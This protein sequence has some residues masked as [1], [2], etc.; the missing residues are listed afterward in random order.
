[1]KNMNSLGGGNNNTE[2]VVDNDE[3]KN[4]EKNSEQGKKS[5]EFSKEDINNGKKRQAIVNFLNGELAA[6][7]KQEVGLGF[8]DEQWAKKQIFSVQDRLKNASNNY[9]ADHNDDA[10]LY[11]V[12]DIMDKINQG[13]EVVDGDE[14]KTKKL[15]NTAKI[16]ESIIS[17]NKKG[18]IS[19]S[20]MNH[21]LNSLEKVNENINKD[22]D[23]R[24]YGFLA[25]KQMKEENEKYAETVKSF[26]QKDEEFRK[27]RSE[28]EAMNG[29]KLT[30]EQRE[31]LKELRGEADSLWDERS[32]LEEVVGESDETRKAKL[33][34]EIAQ[35]E[36]Q[37]AEER[38]KRLETVLGLNKKESETVGDN[39]KNEVREAG[40]DENREGV[41]AFQMRQFMRTGVAGHHNL[42][43][44]SVEKNEKEKDPE[45]QKR[46][47]L[48]KYYESLVPKPDSVEAASFGNGEYIC[49]AILDTDASKQRS[50]EKVIEKRE[51]YLS[52]VDKNEISADKFN[53]L[54]GS[55]LGANLLLN[56]CKIDNGLMYAAEMG[57]E[58]VLYTKMFNNLFGAK[59]KLLSL[60]DPMAAEEKLCKATGK[61]F[62]SD[63]FKDAKGEI[64]KE[65]YEIAL[66]VLN[67]FQVN[68]VN[69]VGKEIGSND[70]NDVIEVFNNERKSDAYKEF[71]EK[72]RM[73][74]FNRSEMGR[75]YNEKKAVADD[76]VKS[77]FDK[78]ADKKVK[79]YMNGANP[80]QSKEAGSGLSAK[81]KEM[82]AEN[83]AEIAK[84][85]RELNLEGMFKRFSKDMA[86]D[87]ENKLFGAS[88]LYRELNS[89]FMKLKKKIE[90]SSFR[91]LPAEEQREAETKRDLLYN[92]SDSLND[93]C[94]KAFQKQKYNIRQSL[95][96]YAKSTK[97]NIIRTLVRNLSFMR[98]R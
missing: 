9:N 17:R 27:K 8:A 96:N 48:K 69:R 44:N 84:D 52:Q 40:D 83:S 10:F 30:G 54:R 43:K 53:F 31:E 72:I 94:S 20:L 36:K 59:N 15:E 4:I 12:N 50:V 49:E 61:P 56:Y 22:F 24:R 90:D 25:E 82:Q 85:L 86:G 2:S 21:K 68:I 71:E 13:A 88:Y 23:L 95:L 55:N 19:D 87:D 7:M 6:Q 75:V 34:S 35:Q 92:I 65:Q 47:E 76:F 45:E 3:N 26:D 58:K 66:N 28:Y 62:D 91:K 16:K 5:L 37:K 93:F 39:E 74:D 63:K 60:Y 42:P 1:M 51:E 98:K 80:Y 41:T 14:T 11:V 38:K 29:G 70:P 77:F 32:K 46:E 67:G 33:A 79:A 18:E 57:N 97:K 78:E 73:N 81:M 89:E 64:S